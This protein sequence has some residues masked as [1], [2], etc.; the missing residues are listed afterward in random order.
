MPNLLNLELL[1]ELDDLADGELDQLMELVCTHTKSQLRVFLEAH[2]LAVSGSKPEIEHRLREALKNEAIT[3]GN[4][5]AFL[6][7]VDG[8]GN[9]HLYLYKINPSELEKWTTERKFRNRLETAGY[10]DL[11]DQVLPVYMPDDPVLSSI[12]WDNHRIRFLWVHRRVWEQR[13]AESDQEVNGDL[14]LR[15]YRRRD[16]RAV[17]WFELDAASGRAILSIQTLPSGTQYATAR[18]ELLDQVR[19]VFPDSALNPVHLGPAASAMDGD[20]TIISRQV[21]LETPR[22]GDVN[23]TSSGRGQDIRRDPDLRSVRAMIEGHSVPKLGNF[24][25]DILRQGD[26]VQRV[27]TKLYTKDHRVGLFGQMWEAEVR[28]VLSLIWSH[29]R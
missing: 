24:Y 25:I 1:A 15:A 11:A 16:A 5:A 14:V 4:L 26:T 21:R 10:L 27:H 13:E 23:L 2:D 8:W 19:S 28:H 12:T 17:N 6:N 3:P 9:Q 18:E 7:E 22:G 20:E 29:C